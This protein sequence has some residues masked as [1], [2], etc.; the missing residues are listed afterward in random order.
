MQNKALARTAP[1]KVRGAGF[2]P[3]DRL[4]AFLKGL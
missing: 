3:G 1:M 2:R 4:L